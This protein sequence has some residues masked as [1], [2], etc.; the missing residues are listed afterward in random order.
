MR[1]YDLTPSVV[2]FILAGHQRGQHCLTRGPPSLFAEI[3]SLIAGKY[4][5]G[6]QLILHFP[7]V[8]PWQAL[9]RP[10]RPV[11]SEMSPGLF[12]ALYS[13]SHLAPDS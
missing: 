8:A 1:D 12:P 3:A 6:S 4:Q 7:V 13:L 11:V 9:A 2:T 5:L 10:V